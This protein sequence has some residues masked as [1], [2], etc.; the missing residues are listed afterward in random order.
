[1]REQPAEGAAAYTR[2]RTFQVRSMLKKAGA[3][4]SRARRG[5]INKKHTMQDG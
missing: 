1:M 3:L 2:H 4:L 5:D